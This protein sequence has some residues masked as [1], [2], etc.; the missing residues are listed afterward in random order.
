MKKGKVGLEILPDLAYD[1][2][3]KWRELH[4]T[5]QR[6]KSEASSITEDNEGDVYEKSYKMLYI[7]LQSRGNNATY[8]SLAHALQQAELIEVRHNYCL[9]NSSVPRSAYDFKGRTM[10]KLNAI[11]DHLD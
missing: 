1:V 10:F 9:V 2:Q 8:A 6:D 3:D 7:W 11:I 4:N 5:L